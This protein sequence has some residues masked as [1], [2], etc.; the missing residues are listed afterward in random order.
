MQSSRPLTSSQGGSSAPAATGPTINVA[1]GPTI[2]VAAGTTINVAAA[3]SE[4]RRYAICGP[5]LLSHG[6]GDR[7]A[8]FPLAQ[9]VAILYKFEVIATIVGRLINLSL[10]YA[11]G[12]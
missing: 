10:I 2:N 6:L 5:Q 8:L 9:C 4:F 12:I 7:V 11:I 3:P 1:A